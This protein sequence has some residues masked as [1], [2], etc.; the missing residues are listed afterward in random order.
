M[1]SRLGIERV[2]RGYL[3]EQRRS[4]RPSICWRDWG[5][6][7]ER[8]GGI[9]SLLSLLLP[10]RVQEVL[11]WSRF[12]GVA[13]DFI[14]WERNRAVFRINTFWESK[15]FC[16]GVDL[17][18]SAFNFKCWETESGR[19]SHCYLLR[20]QEVLFWSVTTL[21]RIAVKGPDAEGWQRNGSGRVGFGDLHCQEK[22]QHKT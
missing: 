3:C 15:K 20:V 18:E 6:G 21:I 7:E 10:L 9:S 16:S 12:A 14:S 2:E 11:F 22:T 4:G 19:I 13:F 1:Q 5:K 8:R 17:Q